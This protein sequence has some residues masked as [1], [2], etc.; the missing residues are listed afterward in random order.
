MIQIL[1]AAAL[2]GALIWA[3]GRDTDSNIRRGPWRPWERS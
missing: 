2:A 3:I 1:L